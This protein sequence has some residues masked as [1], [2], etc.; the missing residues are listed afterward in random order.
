MD[1]FV[2]HYACTLMDVFVYQPICTYGCIA[3]YYYKRIVGYMGLYIH[4]DLT[5]VELYISSR[6][7]GVCHRSYS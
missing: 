6:A 7:Y 4:V 1:V 2:Y 5:L 3:V